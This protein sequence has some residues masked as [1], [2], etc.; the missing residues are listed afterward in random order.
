MTNCLKCNSDEKTFA[1]IKKSI[2]VGYNPITMKRSYILD[3]IIRIMCADC[4]NIE[5][6][7]IVKTLTDKELN[8]LCREVVYRSEVYEPKSI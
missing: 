7:H 2:T 8:S 6:K 4:G 5:E 1:V 3:F